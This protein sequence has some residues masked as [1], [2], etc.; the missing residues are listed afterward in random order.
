MAAIGSGADGKA[1]FDRVV[2][3]CL[4]DAFALARWIAGNRADAEDILQ[5]AC[6]RAYRA[7]DG[8]AEGSARAWM[9]TIVRRTAYSWLDKNRSR[10]V[11]A[12]DELDGSDLARAEGGGDGSR[13]VTTP[14]AELIAKADSAL[15]E[16][17]IAS[18]PTEFRE[19]LVLRD[20]QGLDYREIAT[21]TAVPLGTVM[22]RLARARQRLIETI[23]TQQR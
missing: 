17:A 1:K 4:S 23:G 13:C 21:V 7:I 11:V 19:T 9:L 6:L 16:S 8:F 2:T 20:I 10:A 18:L 12:I 14:E 15:L 3:P 22:S 5:E